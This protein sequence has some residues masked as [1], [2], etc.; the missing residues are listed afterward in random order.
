MH[1]LVPPNSLV[2]YL[3]T[4][5]QRTLRQRMSGQE[6]Q[7]AV[8][9]SAEK[10]SWYAH[11]VVMDEVEHYLNK[12]CQL[13]LPLF[14]GDTELAEPNDGLVV[15]IRPLAEDILNGSGIPSGR[16]REEAVENVT[17]KVAVAAEDA[18]QT[19]CDEEEDDY[20]TRVSNDFD[21][22]RGT[23]GEYDPNDDQLELPFDDKKGGA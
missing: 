9:V 20:E 8:V 19:A 4:W 22:G 23:C 21:R 18:I 12:Q 14:Y 6:L 2:E 16:D 5:A 1:S 17:I 15:A 3:R 7:T 10:I 13:E 11:S